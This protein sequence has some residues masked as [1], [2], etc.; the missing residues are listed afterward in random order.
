MACTII[1]DLPEEMQRKI[2]NLLPHKDLMS[3]M[4]VC[5]S[6][7]AMGQDP[8]MWSLFVVT[9][10]TKVDIQKLKIPRLQKIQGISLCSRLTKLLEGGYQHDCDLQQPD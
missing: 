3:A 5:K 4:L 1:G 2:L 10:H 6:W 8:A 7:K 9:L